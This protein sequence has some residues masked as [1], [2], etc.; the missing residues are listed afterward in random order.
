MSATRKLWA[1]G[2]G[3]L[4]LVLPA[5]ALAEHGGTVPR[6]GSGASKFCVVATQDTTGNVTFEAKGVDQNFRKELRDA[7]TKLDDKYKE[8]V[9]T[10]IKAKSEA[11]KAHE[12]FTDPK[13][14]Q[15]SIQAPFVNDTLKIRQYYPKQEDAKAA[16]DIAQKAF[17][18]AKA[19]RD[20]A[21]VDAEMKAAGSGGG[22]KKPAKPA[23]DK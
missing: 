14:V 7:Q 3:L 12:K 11:T 22:D 15:P 4:A 18:D 5:A 2:I 6:G 17:D 16:A 10:W 19:K 23:D 13:P 1:A 20:A 8:D 9:Q 21:K